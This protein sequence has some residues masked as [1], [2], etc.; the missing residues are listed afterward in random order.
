MIAL[1]KRG[2]K[3]QSA[4]PCVNLV[5]NRP[6]SISDPR[7]RGDINCP[8][9]RRNPDESASTVGIDRPRVTRC[10]Y[11][12]KTAVAWDDVDASP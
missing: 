4:N 1:A 12:S 5:R 10:E 2:K 9:N 11:W 3:R 6:I 7:A 8:S